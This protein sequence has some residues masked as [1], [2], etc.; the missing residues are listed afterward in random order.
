MKLSH[1]CLLGLLAAATTL[2]SA[3]SIW[4]WRDR[5]GRMMVSDRPPPADIPEKNI[6]QRPNG[7]RMMATTD[8]AAAAPSAPASAGLD[9]E[10][11]ARKRKMLQEQAAEKQEKQAQANATKERAS[12]Q[13]AEN[14]QRARNQLTMLQSGVRVARPNAQGEREYLDDK[15]RAAEIAR[16]QQQIS[17]NCN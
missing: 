3:Q 9:K 14:C 6:L 13:K 5:D 17:A 16:T 10:L 8:D 12:A 2:A 15:G 11:E 4:K 1:L 7:P